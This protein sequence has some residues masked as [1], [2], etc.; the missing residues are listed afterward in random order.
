MHVGDEKTL[1]LLEDEAKHVCLKNDRVVDYLCYDSNKPSSASLAS[2]P[3]HFNRR[4]FRKL[5]ISFSGD[6]VWVTVDRDDIGIG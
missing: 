4:G 3:L 2:P 5:F 1:L 6:D